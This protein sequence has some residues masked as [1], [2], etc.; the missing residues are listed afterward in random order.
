MSSQELAEEV[1]KPVI[2]K[3]EKRKVYS[4][5]KDNILGTDFVDMQLISK[6]NKGFCFLLSVVNIFSKYV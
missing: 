5:F 1:H 4:S 3:L 2:R 6:Y